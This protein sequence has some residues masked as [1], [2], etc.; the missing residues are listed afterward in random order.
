[1]QVGFIGLGIMGK[2]MCKNLIKGGY[3]V[4]C[5]NRSRPAVEELVAAGATAS[6]SIAELARQCETI[7]TMLPDSPEVKEVA[8][9]PEGI[10]AHAAAG[11]LL[12]DMSSIAPQASREIHQALAERGIRMIDAPVSGGEPKA[13]DATLSVM[14]GGTPED[15]DAA[16]PIL[17][18]MAASVV[19]VGDIGAG[20]IAKLAN[21]AIV[22]VNIAVLAEALTLAT[23]AG[24]DPALVHAAIRGGLAGSTAMEAKAP[25]MMRGDIRPGFK[26]D[27]HVKDLRNFQATGHDLTVPTPLTALVME[28]MQSLKAAGHGS[29]DHS[30][31]ARFYENISGCTLAVH[32]SE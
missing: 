27:L 10:A 30:A 19:R 23:K 8:L 7:I 32:K 26:I 15:C 4:L 14:V 6:A 3:S 24:A 22:A 9:G 2:P 1:M 18:T 11:T 31:L 21:Q 16:T 29:A 5:F 12:I 28:M 17:K 13:I 20:N 25:M